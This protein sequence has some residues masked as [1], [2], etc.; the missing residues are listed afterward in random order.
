MTDP[1]NGYECH[2]REYIRRRD[3]QTIGRETVRGWAA[4][5]A[6][7]T[8]ILELGAGH[9]RPI[10]RALLDD[11]YRVDAI[12]ASPSLVQAFRR[13]C[14]EARIQCEPVETSTFFGRR[15]DAALAVG[16]LFLLPPERQAAIIARIARALNP[17]G[18]FLF[19]A[20]VEAGS[21][22][23]ILTGQR[24]HS[25]GQPAYRA[26]IEAAGMTLS[27]EMEDEGG[28]HYYNCQV[29]SGLP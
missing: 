20:P 18:R 16:L 29:V 3:Q 4:S 19:T 10:T 11:G 15:Y 23:D 17:G 14:F 21:W 22:P 26:A 5:L 2:A 8:T 13:N 25:L 1:G 12:D 24:S 27:D 28:N 6:P 9:G 7:G